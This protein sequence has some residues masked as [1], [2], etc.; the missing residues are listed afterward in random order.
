MTT[1]K[2]TE[3]SE[4]AAG[5]IAGTDVIPIVDIDAD[6]TKKVTVTSLK[7]VAGEWDGNFTGDAQI[8]GSLIISGSLQVF[9]KSTSSVVIGKNAAAQELAGAEFNVIIG[10]EAGGGDSWHATT[11]KNVMIGY[12]AGRDIDNSNGVVLIGYRAG[13]QVDSVTGGVMIGQE[14]M[15]NSGDNY[16]VGI[17]YYAG[18]MQTRNPNVIIGG[19]AASAVAG[20]SRYNTIVGVKAAYSLSDGYYNTIIG[21]D[22]GY[23]INDGYSN[24]FIGRDAGYNVTDGDDN[25]IIGTR[26][27]GEA[28]INQQLRIGSGSL[29]T[30]SASLVTGEVT[31]RWQRPITTHTTDLTASMDYIGQYNIVG[32]NLTCSVLPDAS[33]SVAVGAEY[34]FF[35]TASVGNFIFYTSSADVTFYSKGGNMTLTGQYSGA[36]LKKAGANT[37]HLVGDLA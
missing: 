37:W 2:I 15:K 29:A 7:T 36:T 32:G 8:S 21:S 28:A 19:N 30:I 20:A 12:Q 23:S 1:K 25:I 18:R 35:Q 33:Q 5:S 9:N 17:G 34:D 10:E 31:G 6:V 22:A 13:Y 14:V 27:L 3:L 24:V 26:N 4:L 11:D 16:G